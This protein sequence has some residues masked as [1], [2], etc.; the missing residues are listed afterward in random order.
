MINLGSGI[1]PSILPLVA[2]CG[3]APYIETTN[4]TTVVGETGY[5][6]TARVGVL[7]ELNNSSTQNGVPSRNPFYDCLADE[8]IAFLRDDEDLDYRWFE[9]QINSLVQYGEITLFCSFLLQNRADIELLL[10]LNGVI[11]TEVDI[12]GTDWFKNVLMAITEGPGQR[13]IQ[14]RNKAEVILGEYF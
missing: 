2:I 11:E 4:S 7:D 9:G 13:S 3:T 12:Y 8:M 5:A 6:E 1:I 10:F 14:L